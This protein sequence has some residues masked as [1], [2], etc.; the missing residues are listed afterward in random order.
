MFYGA[1]SFNQPIGNWDVSNVTAMGRMFGYVYNFNQDLSSWSV[2][3]VVDCYFFNW[4]ATSWA[5]QYY[6]IF[7]NCTP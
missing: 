6:P 3:G 4:G 5:Q 2:D 7:T 1:T